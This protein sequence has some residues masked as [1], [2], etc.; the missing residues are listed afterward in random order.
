MLSLSYR[1]V[2]GECLR[3]MGKV[4]TVMQVLEAGRKLRLE[5]ALEPVR[6]EPVYTPTE[7][8][9]PSS[10]LLVFWPQHRHHRCLYSNL[11]AIWVVKAEARRR[12]RPSRMEKSYI[13]G[14]SHRPI[15]RPCWIG[16]PFT[17]FDVCRNS[18]ECLRA[19]ILSGASY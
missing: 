12:P 1:R 5:S 18:C 7:T 9:S 6:L 16:D 10:L 13:I 4:K 14:R 19:S 17:P 2:D 15:F 3:Q 8:S 11:A